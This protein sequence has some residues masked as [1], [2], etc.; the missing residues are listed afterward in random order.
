MDG[1]KGE[2]D[3]TGGGNSEKTLTFQA[4]PDLRRKTEIVSKF[5]QDQL[6]AH[7]ETLGPILSPER[8]LGKYVGSAGSKGDAALWDRR[9]HQLQLS[10]RSFTARPFDLPSEFDPYWLTLIGNH[11][12]LYPWEYVFEARAG[13]ESKSIA[14]TSPVRWVMSFTS[15]YTLSHVRQALAAKA[16][17]R[18]EHMRQFV[19]NS[20]V[21]QFLIA[22]TPGLVPLFGDLRYQ[23]RTDSASELGGLPLTTITSGLPSFRPS[24]DLIVAATNFS[25][26]PA[27]IELIDIDAL[28][29]LPDPLKLRI[30]DLLR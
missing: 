27:F 21:T 26:V 10:Y 11:L 22:Q 15:A 19:V 25:G 18:P 6:L 17:R 9:V 2:P 30:E 23:L 4:L 5:L 20:L 8:L 29:D 1:R 3:M 12:T 14:M 16:E 13:A 28:V 24:D 7:L